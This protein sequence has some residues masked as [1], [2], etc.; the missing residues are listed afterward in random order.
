SSELKNGDTVEIITDQR[1]SP[2]RDWLKFVKTAKARTR[3]NYWIR[4]EERAG[5]IALAKEMLEKEGRKIGVNA[6]KALKEGKFIPVAEE[7]SYKSVD[8]LLA[9]VGYARLT[10]RQILNKLLP[11]AEIQA[12]PEGIEVGPAEAEDK[13]RAHENVR[14]KGVDDV[15]IRFAKCCNPVPGDPIIG[16]ISRG[17]GVT[18]HRNDCPNVLKMESERLLN[19]SWEEEQDRP[20]Q[21]RIKIVCRNERGMLSKISDI[22]AREGVNIDSGR[23]F[24]NLEGNTVL[25]FMVEVPDATYLYQT[26]EKLSRLEHVFEVTRTTT[27]ET[28]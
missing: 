17:R 19:V 2:S 21:A 4:T 6:A 27:A 26:I 22:L 7:F 3:I 5:S 25:L 10:P 20:Y 1:R 16:Y 23:F 12:E 9:A 15:L 8:D 28:T 13:P 14:I 18:V 11:K 24:S